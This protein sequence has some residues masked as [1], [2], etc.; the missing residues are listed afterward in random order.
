MSKKEK[1]AKRENQYRWHNI[2]I[3]RQD[4]YIRYVGV[5][6]LLDFESG[7]WSTDNLALKVQRRIRDWER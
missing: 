5:V 7:V 3:I 6:D 1:T 2:V 4:T